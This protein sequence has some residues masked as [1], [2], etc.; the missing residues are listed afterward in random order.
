MKNKTDKNDNFVTAKDVSRI[1]MIPLSTVYRLTQQG[2]VRAVRIGGRWYYREHEIRDY[3]SGSFSPE[4]Y[5]RSDNEIQERR[6]Y[7]RMNCSI[8]CRYSIALPGGDRERKGRVKNISAGGLLLEDNE[9]NINIED[10]LE[11]K[12]VLEGV[13]IAAKGRIVR[14]AGKEFGIKFRSIEGKYRDLVTRYIG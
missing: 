12:F 8:D 3:L 11:V 6:L 2:A 13:A 5:R 1:L 9:T 4:R 10:P 14:K 7:P